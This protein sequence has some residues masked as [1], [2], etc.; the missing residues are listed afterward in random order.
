M[1][2]IK[3]GYS[4]REVARR[5][6]GGKGLRRSRETEQHPSRGTQNR[7]RCTEVSSSHYA[8]SKFGDFQQ[9]C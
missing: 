5:L 2:L 4:Q 8:N 3:K 9:V 6:G 1:A 7:T